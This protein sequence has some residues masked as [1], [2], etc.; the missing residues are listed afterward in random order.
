PPPPPPALVGA[1]PFRRGREGAHPGGA[2][3]VGADLF[4][5]RM[6]GADLRG[7]RMEGA[8]LSEARMEGAN[9]RGAVFDYSLMWYAAATSARISGATFVGAGLM[10]ADVADPLDL[11]PAAFADALSA[12]FGDGSVAL[13]DGVTRPDHW[14]DDSL[15]EA[16]FLSRWRGWREA[17]GLPW[18]PPGLALSRR[19]LGRERPHDLPDIPATPPRPPRRHR[20]DRRLTPAAPRT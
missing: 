11:D 17:S 15:T 10:R 5:A 6:E 1:H 13:P 3:M 12:A 16:A 4:L 8:D 18:P 2:R 20:G 14:P 7:A 9:L 19:V